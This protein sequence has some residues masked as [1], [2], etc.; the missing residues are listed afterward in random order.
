M[1]KRYGI[2][3]G[4]VFLLAHLTACAPR[5]HRASVDFSKADA[6]IQT[7]VDEAHIPGA[8]LL[9][10]TRDRVLHR[11]AFGMRAIQP[12]PEVMTA[13]TVFDLASLTKP[14]A[15]ATSILVLVDRGLVRLDAKV[16]AY[17]PEFANNGKEVITVEQLLTHTSGLTPDNHLRDYAD[18]RVVA[19]EKVNALA[20]RWKPGT[21]FHYSDVGYIVLGMIVQR[22][23]G[24]RVDEFARQNVFEPVGM[25][26]A[27][28]NPPELT[29]RRV[30]PTAFEDGA[31]LRGRV[32]DPRAAAMEGVAGHAGLFASIDDLSRYC[33]MILKGGAVPARTCDGRGD[34]GRYARTA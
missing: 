15:T 19:I 17:L 14:V 13:E 25:A 6:I 18:G 9:V 20:P 7:A 10:G 24:L 32:H 29:R 16:G 1:L 28:F 21:E 23:S 22:V 8:V 34:D 26:S 11:R 31:W 3:L 30:A 4:L 2:V 5:T 12:R 27:G 33:Q